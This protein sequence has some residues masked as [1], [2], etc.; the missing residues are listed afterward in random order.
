MDETELST[1]DAS[2]LNDILTQQT[3]VVPNPVVF[4][5]SCPVHITDE[6]VRSCVTPRKVEKVREALEEETDRQKLAIRLLLQFFT[7]EEL[8]VGNTDGSCKKI[9]LDRSRLHSLKSKATE[10]SLC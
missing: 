6:L 5:S 8:A 2:S 7:K 4:E 3:P 10:R 9:P 1:I